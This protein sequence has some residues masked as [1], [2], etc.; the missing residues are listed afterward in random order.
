MSRYC[1]LFPVTRLDG[2]TF[3]HLL[4]QFLCQ[5]PVV[6][7]IYFDNHG[8]FNNEAADR[9]LRKHGLPVSANTSTPYSHQENGLVERAIGEIQR[10]FERW[11][12]TH[13]A[14]NWRVYYL[15]TV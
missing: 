9:V 6:Q 1:R 11:R 10:H 3:A 4:D 8:Q 15:P 7:A 12:H 5:V 14:D 13:P 2:D